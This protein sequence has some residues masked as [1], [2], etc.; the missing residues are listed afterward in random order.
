M[1][2][3]TTTWASM[4]GSDTAKRAAL[5]SWKGLM[6]HLL[7]FPP[8]R[9]SGAV[10]RWASGAAE[11]LDPDSMHMHVTSA[12][13]HY[14]QA[15]EHE[16]ARVRLRAFLADGVW[17]RYWDLW[18]WAEPDRAAAMERQVLA[19]YAVFTDNP[20][21]HQLLAL[22]ALLREHFAPEFWPGRT[23]VQKQRAWE[24]WVAPHALYST[25]E[26][27]AV[28]GPRPKADLLRAMPA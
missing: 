28:Q 13:V 16:R 25:E 11:Y 23:A 15:L 12:H 22:D 14:S 3:A 7:A 4:R 21:P 18:V 2:R 5:R 24:A 1:P 27:L 9:R 26:R 10:F 17:R 19:G 20:V 6:S 8:V